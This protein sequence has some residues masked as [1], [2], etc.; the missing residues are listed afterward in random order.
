MSFQKKMF[1]LGCHIEN[2]G[3]IVANCADKK[4]IFEWKWGCD[5]FFQ[6]ELKIKSFFC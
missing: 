2:F 1:I 5:W 3:E 6:L 4:I